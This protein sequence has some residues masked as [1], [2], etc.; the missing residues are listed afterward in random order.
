MAEVEWEDIP[1]VCRD[2]D[3]SLDESM[4]SYEDASKEHEPS[5]GF[6][7]SRPELYCSMHGRQSKDSMG[8]T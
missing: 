8:D 1:F 3:S 2:E 4:G 5:C 7:D 6:D